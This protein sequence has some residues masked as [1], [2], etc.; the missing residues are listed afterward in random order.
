MRQPKKR[1]PSQAKVQ[2]AWKEFYDT[3]EGRIAIGALM[4]RSGVYSQITAN[5][6]V[7]AG[8]EIG[9]RN[10]GAWLAEIIGM[11]AETTYVE[12]VV[13]LGKAFEYEV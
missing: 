9:Q 3:P 13:D 4:A 10:I 11:K 8:I 6:P 7:M 12:E 1:K 2:A 5:D